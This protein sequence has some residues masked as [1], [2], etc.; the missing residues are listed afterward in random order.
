MVTMLPFVYSAPGGD[1]GYHTHLAAEE[2]ALL[3]MN[4]WLAMLGPAV[5][6]FS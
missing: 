3:R 6:L 5:P 2:T 1:L 4:D